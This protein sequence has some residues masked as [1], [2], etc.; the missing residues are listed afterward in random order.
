MNSP[1]TEHVETVQCDMMYF[2]DIWHAR[3]KLEGIGNASIFE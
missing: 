3:S 2:A 1:S